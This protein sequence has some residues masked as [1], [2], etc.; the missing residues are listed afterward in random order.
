MNFTFKRFMKIAVIV[1]IIGYLGCARVPKEV[2]ELSY[3]VGKDINAV[4]DSYRTLI[5]KYF[6]TLRM[7][8]RD[9][10]DNTWKPKYLKGFIEQGNLV[11]RARD[12]DP[13]EAL[14]KVQNWVTVALETIEQMRHVLF[15]PIDEDEK[16]LLEDVAQSFEQLTTANATITAHLNSIRKVEE[17]Q[18]NALKALGLKDVRDKINESLADASKRVKYTIDFVKEVEGITE[19]VGEQKKEIIKQYEEL[20]KKF[21]ELKKKDK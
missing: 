9:F 14:I 5:H 16:K 18:D 4:H 10:F 17:V 21:E 11:E 20:K 7:Q 1:M 8:T 13:K 19:E 2:V 6:D 3:T 12:P 15:D